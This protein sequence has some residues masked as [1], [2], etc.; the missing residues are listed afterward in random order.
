VPETKSL[1]ITGS[2]QTEANVK[3]QLVLRELLFMEIAS[4][5]EQSS[6][7]EESRKAALPNM[8]GAYEMIRC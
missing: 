3:K 6:H 5:A 4:G 8:T 7:G 2:S 1:S